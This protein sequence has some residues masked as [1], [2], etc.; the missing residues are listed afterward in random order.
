MGRPLSRG[1]VQE[2]R[3][4]RVRVSSGIQ[5]RLAVCVT[6]PPRDRRGGLQPGSG[7]VEME[8]LERVLMAAK[9]G[10][11]GAAARARLRCLSFLLDMMVLGER[12]R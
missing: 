12:R 9:T 1:V 6:S 10:A 8:A 7:R 2:E 5:G 11:A 4:P 3:S